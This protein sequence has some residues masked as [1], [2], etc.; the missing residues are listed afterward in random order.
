[1]RGRS[2]I[3]AKMHARICARGELCVLRGKGSAEAEKVD[4]PV[5]VGVWMCGRGGDGRSDAP[6]H[7]V[8]RVQLHHGPKG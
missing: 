5:G 6:T 7:L 4:G 8:G 2:R 1:M 3:H